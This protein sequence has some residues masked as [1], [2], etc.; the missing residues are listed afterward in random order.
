MTLKQYIEARGINQNKLAIELGISRQLVGH[1]VK[2]GYLVGN[3]D[4][5]MIMFNPGEVRELKP[6]YPSGKDGV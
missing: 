1:K 5:I 2:Q 4:G 6:F 3:L